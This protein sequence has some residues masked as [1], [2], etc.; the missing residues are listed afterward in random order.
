MLCQQNEELWK[1][2]KF[3]GPTQQY[4]HGVS[5]VEP[6]C[7]LFPQPFPWFRPTSTIQHSVQEPLVE[8]VDSLP[9]NTIMSMFHNTYR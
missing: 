4:I 5:Q 8:R 1:V 2:F 9:N 6:F 7:Q 3:G